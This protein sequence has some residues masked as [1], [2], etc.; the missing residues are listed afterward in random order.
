ME[1]WNQVHAT[2]SIDGENRNY[3][4]ISLVQKFGQHH[5]FDI[6]VLCSPLV[7][8]NVWHHEREEMIALQGKTV[9]IRMKHEFSGDESI[10][11]GIITSIGMDGDKGVSGT[12]HYRGYSTTILLESGRTM[13]S[14]TDATL[15]EIVSEVVEKYGNGISIVNNPAFKSRI[16]YVQMQEE[17]AYEF[18]RRL[19]WQYG[20]WF[21]YN[22]QVL[23]FGNPYK[24]KDE[25][26]VYDIDMDSMHFSSCVAPFHFSRHDYLSDS[27][28]DMFGDD[29]EAV[30]GINTY[31]ANAMKTSEGMYRSQTTMY[32]HTATGHPLDIEHFTAVEK[33]RKVSSLVWMTGNTKTCRV[34]IGEPVVVQIPPNMCKRRDMGRYR[35]VELTHRIEVSGGYA[36]S[37]KG[38]P[39]SMEYI[40]TEDMRMPVAHAMLAE[41]TDNADPENLGRVQVQF[42]WQKNRNK[43]TN[44][45][46]VRS[47][48]AG[49]SET[50]S[51]NRGFVFVPEIGDQVMVDFELGDPCRPYVSGSMF[52]KNNGEGGNA[53]NHIKTIV[54]RS[55]HTL[56]FNDDEDGQWGITITDK[57]NNIIRLD[58]KNKA[59][60]ISSQEKII[61]ESKDIVV[62]ANNNLELLASKVTT[63]QGDELLVC[64][65]K[66]MQTEVENEYQ[67]NAKT[68]TEITEKTEIQSTKENL[69]L[70]SGKEVVAN[71]K[72]KKIR[73]S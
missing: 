52:H 24:E 39:A 62:S 9:V 70:S 32:S 25:N 2:V 28:M 12:L 8:E 18:L 46:R 47:L 42:A 20:E 5:Y 58:T 53:D 35:I 36:N 22:G 56:E 23:Y 68:M 64:R 59:I 11:K 14:F 44:W 51:K 15:G 6:E 16:P 63:I 26:L 21:Y 73:L 55:G 41:V 72:S 19:A 71:S 7:K 67:L 4:R 38:I 30:R 49:S 40:P 43:T 31:L 50:V 48:D 1:D 54:T 34:R 60:S 29:S 61:I 69:L 33:G 13:D 10:F 45:I 17:S 57:E 3:T 37:F 65:T 27:H 66:E